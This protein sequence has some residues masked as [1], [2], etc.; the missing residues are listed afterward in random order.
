MTQQDR[1]TLNKLTD[2]LGAVEGGVRDLTV[3]ICG[4]GTKGLN[5][6]QTESEVWQDK[7]EESHM[8]FLQDTS[9]YRQEREEKEADREHAAKIRAYGIMGSVVV[10]IV[11]ALI[12]MIFFGG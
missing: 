2:R 11:T 3:A 8:L 4:N 9:K 7:H 10:F 1:D 12:K 6:R 5:Q